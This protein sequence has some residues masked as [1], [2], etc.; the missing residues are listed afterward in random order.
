MC[1]PSPA[2]LIRN[3][4][5]DMPRKSLDWNPHVGGLGTG[6]HGIERGEKGEKRK[7]C[8]SGVTEYDGRITVR[9]RLTPNDAL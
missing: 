2:Y 5:D 6:L 4:N 1:L 9:M 8:G 3:N 7:S